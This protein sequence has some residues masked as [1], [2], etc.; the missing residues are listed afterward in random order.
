MASFFRAATA[1]L[2]PLAATLGASTALAAGALSVWADETSDKTTTAKGDF[3][4]F[5]DDITQEKIKSAYPPK[6][7][8]LRTNKVLVDPS[9]KEKLQRFAGCGVKLGIECYV[10][11]GSRQVLQLRV[12]EPEPFGEDTDLSHD[13]VYLVLSSVA[14]E[15]E[16][17]IAG[18]GGA[19]A[20]ETVVT[21]LNHLGHFAQ[22][23][24]KWV[25][26]HALR[27]QQLLFTKC[28]TCVRF[29]LLPFQMTTV[30][31]FLLSWHRVE[32]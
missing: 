28:G 10:D 8:V 18:S 16:D 4:V 23:T 7:P 13:K 12:L 2:R 26:D 15:E 21:T 9:T 11:D 17:E 6:Y 30:C 1:R 5:F 32:K 19:N 27:L 25:G 14:V 29:R 24:D 22:G 31:A 20:R 3:G